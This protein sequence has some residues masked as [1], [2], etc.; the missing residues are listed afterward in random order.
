MGSFKM[1]CLSGFYLLVEVKPLLTGW[2]WGAGGE[3]AEKKRF[4]D[5]LRKKEG[6]GD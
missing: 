4:L 3:E 1:L 2:W 5:L 6:F